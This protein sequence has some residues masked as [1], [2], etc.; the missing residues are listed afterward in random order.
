MSRRD[1]PA[2][3]SAWVQVDQRQLRLWQLICGEVAFQLWLSELP[4]VLWSL[5]SGRSPR[6]FWLKGVLLRVAQ[7]DRTMVATTTGLRQ[8]LIAVS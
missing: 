5:D 6:D 3:S 8:V 7:L 2:T 1:S 4:K